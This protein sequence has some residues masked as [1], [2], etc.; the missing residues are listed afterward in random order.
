[1]TGYITSTFHDVTV[2]A[3]HLTRL[4]HDTVRSAVGEYARQ[5]GKMEGRTLDPDNIHEDDAVALV[6]AV[7]AGHAAG[8]VGVEV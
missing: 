6:E 4:D 5:I 2:A 7:V 8:D 1:M 3:R